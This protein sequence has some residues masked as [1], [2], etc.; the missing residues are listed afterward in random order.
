[1]V[2]M[3]TAM[4]VGPVKAV[5]AHFAV[6]VT[7]NFHGRHS[8]YTH[9]R[10]RAR[11]APRAHP[12]TPMQDGHMSS[13]QT[14]TLVGGVP[15]PVLDRLGELGFGS[16]VAEEA[17]AGGM[18]SRTRRLITSSGATVVLKTGTVPPGHYRSETWGLDAMRGVPGWVVPDVFLMREN[19]LL[20]SDL[21]PQRPWQEIHGYS[22][23]YWESLGRGLAHLHGRI[24][25]RFGFQKDTYWGML[26]FDNGWEVDGWEFYAER[27]YR[28]FLRRKHLRTALSTTELDQLE[29]ISLR[30]RELI[31]PQPPCLCHG[32]L[33]GGNR[34]ITSDGRAAVIDPF[35]HYGWAEADLY[36]CRMWGGFAPRFFDAYLESHP[37]EPGWQQRSEVY[38]LLHLLAMVELGHSW[39]LP[40]TRTLLKRFGQAPEPKRRRSPHRRRRRAATAR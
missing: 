16:P 18:V 7:P 3:A 1:M 8:V 20:L 24:G 23:A 19:C 6:G 15:T 34:A 37:L 27:R 40:W 30:L 33:W 4:A 5:K 28:W 21:G 13:S 14:A 25:S 10:S 31:P 29:R 17:L 32:D 11:A 35:I 2:P 39:C 9:P 36:N 38:Y 26:R 12:L 22:D